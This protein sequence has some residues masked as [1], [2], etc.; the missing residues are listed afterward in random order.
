MKDPNG[1]PTAVELL[2]LSSGLINHWQRLGLRLDVKQSSIDIILR[3]DKDFHTHDLKAHAMLQVWK[4]G[5]TSFTNGKLA[6]ALREEGLVRLAM[7]FC[8]A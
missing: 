5:G 8:V 7:K 2:D 4:D 6:E 1:E 3:N